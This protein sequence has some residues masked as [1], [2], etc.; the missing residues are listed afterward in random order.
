MI[1]YSTSIG[2]KTLFIAICW[3]LTYAT[4]LVLLIQFLFILH[5]SVQGTQ[6]V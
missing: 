3:H 4:G 1:S 6:L 5:S 2:N